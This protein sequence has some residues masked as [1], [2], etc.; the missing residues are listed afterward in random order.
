DVQNMYYSARNIFQKKV[1]FEN[2]VKDAVGK[3]KLVRAIAYAVG[4][5]TAEEQP[6]ID[7]LQSTGIETRQK[8]LAEYDSGQKKADW[9]VG[10]A[11]DA[12]KMLDMVDVVVLVS[13]DG[14]FIP[15]VEY[16]QSRGRIMETYS[17]RETTSSKLLEHVDFYTNLSDNKKRYLISTPS[18]YQSKRDKNKPHDSDA[19]DEEDF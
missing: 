3:R 12:I 10:I 8:V 5:K 18:R 13:G 11:I 14:D 2:I 6:F 1:N 19:E 9:D 7:A 16:I 4:T 15:L 17:F